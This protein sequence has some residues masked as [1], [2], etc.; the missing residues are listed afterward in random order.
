MLVELKQVI[1]LSRKMELSRKLEKY[2]KET[3]RPQKCRLVE[4]TKNILEKIS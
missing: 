2:F 4:G 3:S 1:N